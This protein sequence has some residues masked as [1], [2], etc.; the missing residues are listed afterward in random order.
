ML[1][2]MA[3][4]RSRNATSLTTLAK[5]SDANCRVLFF[6][7]R[8]HPADHFAGAAVILNNIRENLS[9]LF[10]IRRIRRQGIAAPP[11]RCSVSP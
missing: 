5:S 2:N 4:L 6:D 8:A 3:S 10:E 7:Q 9:H 11:A 1:C